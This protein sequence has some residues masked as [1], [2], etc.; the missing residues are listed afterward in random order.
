MSS[1]AGVR[2]RKD[3]FVYGS[4][5]AGLDAFAQGLG[6]SLVGTGVRVM[7]VRPG[8]VHTKMTEGMDAAPFSTTAEQ[9]ADVIVSGLASGREVV[10][11]PPVLRYPFAVLR[12]LPRA[13]WR[14]VAER[15]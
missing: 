14:K 9:V 12:N 11:A 4:T 1:V 6:D 3:N 5:K 15:G 10:Y 13:I 8:F 7:V 2:A